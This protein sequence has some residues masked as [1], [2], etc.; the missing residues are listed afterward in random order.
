MPRI[1]FEYPGL[2]EYCDRTGNGSTTWDVCWDCYTLSSEDIW[3]ELDG[4][5]ESGE[6]SPTNLQEMTHED[7]GVGYPALEEGETCYCDCCGDK[8]NL[9]M[10]Y[11]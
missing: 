1:A 6:P 4:P 10:D 7:I 5:S 3:V 11:R 9:E 2:T 8:L